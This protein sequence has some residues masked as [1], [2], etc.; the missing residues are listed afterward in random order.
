MIATKGN[1]STGD[2]VRITGVSFRNLDYWARTKFIAPSIADAKG[3]GTDRIYSFSDLLALR[4]TRELREAGISTQS[5]RRVVDFLRTRKS[6]TNPL[7]ECHLIVTGS[8]VQVATSPDKI[9][10]ALRKPGQTSF[11]FL[12][13]LARTIDE[14]KQEIETSERKPPGRA[15]TPRPA[16]RRA[17]RRP[18]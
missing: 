13:D 14:M 18:A 1:F 5:L 12:F 8:D 15:L 2:A 6:L 3:T 16:H 9:M 7:A 17:V 10:S 11:T 4:V